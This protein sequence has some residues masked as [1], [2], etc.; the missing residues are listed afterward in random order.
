MND[1]MRD[2]GIAWIGEIPSD[3]HIFRLKYLSDF[4]TGFTPDTSRADY[5]SVDGIPW[6]TIADMNERVIRSSALSP[7]KL[8]IDRFKPRI[9]KKGT[10]LFSFK[11]SAGKVAFAGCDLYT[12]EAIA[13]FCG[14]SDLALPF[15]YY[16]AVLIPENAGEN[17]YGA[18][19]MNQRSI[20]DAPL[21]IPPYSE[22]LEIAAYL[23]AV[24]ARC[25]KQIKLIKLQIRVLEEHRKTLIHETVTKGLDSG[26]PMKD[27]GVEWIGSIPSSWNCK[28]LKYILDF[29][30]EW[31]APIES[32]LRSHDGET[33]YPY[34][35]ASGIIDEIDAYNVSGT[36]ILL[37]EDGANILSRS[38]PLAFISSGKYWVNNHAHILSPKQGN[39]RYY[40]YVLESV[41]YTCFATGSAQPKL[42]QER[43]SS[44]MLPEPPAF[45][46]DQIADYLDQKCVIIDKTLVLKREQLE[47]LRKYR[48]SV[49]YEYV[50]GKRRVGQE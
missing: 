32:S 50:T 31:R 21:P 33:L 3:W 39:L 49:I 4:E 5:Y 34:Y 47:T 11:L 45:E 9:V 41:D 22:Q 15:L 13:S 48:Q 2:S 25:D 17:I 7:S 27:S 12:N 18:K 28:R 42:S 37:G 6:V 26:V 46:Q 1:L 29:H 40:C 35:G 43:L 19:I 30:D 36:Y 44:V 24:C 23:D 14:S 20:G 16:A 8:Y 10:V 38:T